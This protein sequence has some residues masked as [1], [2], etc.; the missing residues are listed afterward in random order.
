V[1]QSPVVTGDFDLKQVLTTGFWGRDADSTTGSY[2]PLAVLTFFVDFHL[3]SGHPWTFHVTNVVLHGVAAALLFVFLAARFGRKIAAFGALFFAF[4]AIHTENVAGIVARA[5]VMAT[6]F[7]LLAL[8]LA[9]S[10]RLKI[11]VLAGPVLFLGLMS[12]EIAVAVLAVALAEDVLGLD[13][14]R[15][16]DRRTR[17]LAVVGLWLAFALYLLLRVVALEM[18]A[19][20]V[21][22]VGNPLVDADAV[23]RPL[24]SAALLWKAFSMMV[25]PLTLS[26]DYSFPEIMPYTSIANFEVI[27][28][29]LV[30]VALP[31]T[32]LALR[33]RRPAVALGAA[34]FLAAYFPISNAALLIPAIF[35]ERLLYLPSVGFAL[36]VAA[37]LVPL[38]STPRYRR[39]AAAAMMVL[40]LFNVVRS[41]IRTR[42]WKSQRTLFEAAMGREDWQSAVEALTVAVALGPRFVK[43]RSYLGVT[44]D[45]LNQPDQAFDHFFTA[46]RLVPTCKQCVQNLIGFYSRYGR[47][48][49]AYAEIQLYRDAGGDPTLAAAL[50][51]RVD[52]VRRRA[53]QE[54]LK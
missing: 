33:K 36:I 47:F 27:A 40:L 17:T 43:A 14:T 25:L 15:T 11:A 2:R 22:L 37:L 53:R 10:P 18:V 7:S 3:G 30:W 41:G 9:R 50:T 34:I 46:V 8:H 48:K 6:I 21:G 35:A 26:A 51:E 12:K 45:M 31:A 24:T 28:G 1:A 32:M 54:G 16:C 4:H 42:D 39:L 23:A 20:P 13:P 5:D 19:A 44:H 29:M 52:N 38:L 49:A